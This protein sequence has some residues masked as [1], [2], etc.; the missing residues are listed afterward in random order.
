MAMQLTEDTKTSHLMD[1]CLA[2]KF[3]LEYEKP[4]EIQLELKFFIFLKAMVIT[5]GIHL[6]SDL[7]NGGVSDREAACTML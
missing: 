3:W 7:V 1:M 6:C 4:A 2:K 5:V